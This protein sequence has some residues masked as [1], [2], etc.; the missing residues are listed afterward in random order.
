MSH[1]LLFIPQTL[2]LVIK[3]LKLHMNVESSIDYKQICKKCFEIIKSFLEGSSGKNRMYISQLKS[4]I[5]VRI[6]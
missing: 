4:H 5:F 2:E 1:I 3:L 6:E